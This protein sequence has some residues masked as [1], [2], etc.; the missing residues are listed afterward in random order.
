MNTDVEDIKGKLTVL[1]PPQVYTIYTKLL[2]LF[3]WYK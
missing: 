1:F 2:T 3:S